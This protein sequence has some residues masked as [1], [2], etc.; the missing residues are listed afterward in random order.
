M[1]RAAERPP[2]CWLSVVDCPRSFCR[3]SR[4]PRVDHHDAEPLKVTHVSGRDGCLASS[5]DPGNLEVAD[6]DRPARLAAFRGDPASRVCSSRIEWEHASFE[7]LLQHPG[8][9]ILENASPATRC[10]KLQAH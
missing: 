10:Q 7:V 2:F 5:G 9:R 6:L 4:N 3:R 8:K 1:K